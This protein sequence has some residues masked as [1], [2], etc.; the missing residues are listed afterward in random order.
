MP[1][2]Y[3]SGLLLGM[4]TVISLLLHECGHIL[5][6]GILGV[7]VHEIGFC[8]R[9]PYN[10]RERARVPIEEVAITLSGPMVNAL[11]AAALWT[12]P[13]VGHWLAIYNLVLLVSNLAPLPGSDGRR[14][15]AAWVQATTKARV[16]V[17]VHKN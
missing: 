16:P 4:L 9:G 2:N 5:A 13:G 1:E 8:L 15:F 6:A 7:K 17:V 11:T 10:R 3:A 12:V 14:V